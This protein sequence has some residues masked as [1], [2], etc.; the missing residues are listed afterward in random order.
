[1]LILVVVAVVVIAL[2]ALL[3]VVSTSTA[4]AMQA[5][6]TYKVAQ[7]AYQQSSAEVLR[8][9][10]GLI[11]ALI[12]LIALALVCVY[13]IKRRVTMQQPQAR[14]GKWVGGPN[15]HWARIEEP[16]P[17]PK[18]DPAQAMTLLM[19]QMMQQ[20]SRPQT[21]PQ[22]PAQAPQRARDEQEVITWWN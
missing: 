17:M 6:A 20:N 15:A 10:I 7:V 2:A 4:S 1:M 9:V 16:Q 8:Q 21:P 22:L 5:A 13:L 18:I 19:L 14:P 11:V 3:A 12:I